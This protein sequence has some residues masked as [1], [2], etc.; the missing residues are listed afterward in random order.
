LTLTPVSFVPRF[1]ENEIHKTSLKM[2]EA[3]M[4]RKK[5]DVILEMLK[6]ERAHN[7]RI[8]RRGKIMFSKESPI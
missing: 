1:L 4:V 7:I 6:K 8:L 3:D 2:M 5:Y